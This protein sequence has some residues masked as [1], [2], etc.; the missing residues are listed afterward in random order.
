MKRADCLYSLEE[1]VKD[2]QEFI[3]KRR[4]ALNLDK[5][6]DILALA[7]SGG[8]IRSATFNLGLLQAFNKAG[9]LKRADYISTVSGGGYISSYIQK[10]L[11]HKD[12]TQ[13][14]SKAEIK[15]LK[16]YGDYLKPHKGLRKFYESITFYLSFIILAILHI[17][18]YILFFATTIIGVLTLFYY[19]PKIPY[20]IY[21]AVTVLFLS[22]LLW[23]YFMHPLRHI[24]KILW[25][26]KT[27]FYLF[28][29]FFLLFGV[30]SLS[31]YNITLL[32]PYLAQFADF[33]SLIYLSLLVAA[34]GFFSNPNILSMHQYYRN[35]ITDAY[36][37][38]KFTLADTPSALVIGNMGTEV[39]PRRTLRERLRFPPAPLLPSTSTSD[40]PSNAKF[41]LKK[42][43]IKLSSLCSN[44]FNAPYPLFNSTLN[45][46][47]DKR[48]KGVKSCDYFLFSPLYCGS[49]LTGYVKSSSPLYKNFTVAEAATISG[50]ALN[51]LM[52][53]KSNRLI[54]FILTLFNIRLG[55]WSI[56][57]LILK[58]RRFLDRAAVMFLYSG[59][60][61]LPVFWPYYNLAEL[62]GKMNLNRWMINLSDGGGIENLGAFELF[63]REAKIIICSDAGADPK[64]QFDDLRNL[65]LRVRNEL[66]IEVEFSSGNRVE[67]EIYPQPS[68]GY[69]KRHFV[70]GRYYK[71]SDKGKPKVALGYFVYIKSSVTAPKYKLKKETRSE[72][73][74]A[75]KNHHPSFPHEPTV[76]QFFDA[77]QW[78][79]YR[80]LGEEAGNDFIKNIENFSDI[81]S[82]IKSL[83]KLAGL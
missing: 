36:L 79:A 5:S 53:Y 8:G 78:E 81:D 2:E 59:F 65:L 24:N 80:A 49:K 55:F 12:F 4:D 38:P 70:T 63:R 68:S 74:Y 17:L 73:Y 57:P 13:L 27:L 18:W 75:Y 43:D 16:S 71:L 20:E 72:D 64:Y 61:A 37:N 47:A 30:F 46:Q 9:I 62:F 11:Q 77:H 7:L 34:T 66:E 26:S 60:K 19:L 39:K 33:G 15:R 69:S 10:E 23:Y 52:G 35:K 45:L 41:G 3:F 14:F 67:N 25:S 1:I 29:L 51:S 22:L 31:Y 56:N 50:A 28:A 44:S 58:G 83:D 21:S 48:I 40:A 82:L 42:E 76:D 6:K 32:P 54:S